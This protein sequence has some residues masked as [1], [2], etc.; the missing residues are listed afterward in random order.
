MTIYNLVVLSQF[1]TSCYFMSRS[2]CCFWNHIQISQD[3]HKVLWC[4][5]LFKNFPQCVLIH[6]VKGFHVV[7][8]TDV[9]LEFPC[10]LH[11]PMNGGNLISGLSDSLKPI[12]HIWKFS[13]HT[14]LKPNLK[15]SEHNLAI[16]LKWVQLYSSF[17]IL[18]HF[19]S[20][21]LKGKLTFS[22]VVAT[23]ELSKFADIL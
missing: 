6:T 9:F 23:A 21:G 2:N 22:S 5:H 11:D 18:W 17:K 20:L 16:M 19:P 13:V 7:N 1:W 10:L 3:T 14:L 8:E 12:L 4:S 15:D